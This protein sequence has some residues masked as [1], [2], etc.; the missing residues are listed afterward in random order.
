MIR[1][2]QEYIEPILQPDPQGFKTATTR[3]HKLIKG[4][5]YKIWTGPRF[6]PV[7]TGILIEINQIYETKPQ[8]L[9]I[10]MILA[11][12]GETDVWKYI[13]ILNGINPKKE[14]TIGSIIYY[15]EFTRVNYPQIDK[16]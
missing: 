3:L 2:R 12:V 1:F 11:D 10:K 16:Y 7:D 8:N 15:H 4:G 6:K 13:D 14:I 9:S 5:L